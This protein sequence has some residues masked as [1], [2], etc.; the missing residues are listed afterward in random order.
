MARVGLWSIRPFLTVEDLVEA[1]VTAADA[2]KVSSIKLKRNRRHH[3]LRRETT[4]EPKAPR[5]L[6]R[7]GVRGGTTH[8]KNGSQKDMAQREH[9]APRRRGRMNAH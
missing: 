4:G 6:G 3:S 9:A 1:G 7:L 8:T 2:R 5:V